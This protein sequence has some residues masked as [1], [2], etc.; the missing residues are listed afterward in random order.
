MNS[1]VF[2]GTGEIGSLIRVGLRKQEQLHFCASGSR[3]LYDETEGQRDN[4]S[5]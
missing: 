3:M 5:L 1:T 4:N 2:I